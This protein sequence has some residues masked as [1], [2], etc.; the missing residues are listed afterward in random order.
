ME[1][2][3]RDP[4]GRA[5]RRGAR[6]D[7]RAAARADGARAGDA[8]AVRALLPRHGDRATSGRRDVGDPR[9]DQPRRVPA[10]ARASAPGSR[11]RCSR[12]EEEARYGYLAAVNSTTLSDGVALD[13]G[14]GSMQLTRGRAT[15]GR[16]DARSWPLGAVRMTERF[17]R[18]G[19]GQAQAAQGAARA[20][21]RRARGARRGSARRGGRLAGIGGTVR[22]LA[23]AAELAERAAVLRRPGLRARRD[24]LDDLVERLAEL[25]PRRARQRARASSPSAAT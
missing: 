15:G 21:A 9:R 11:S 1:A 23:A 10:R 20:R 13:L 17:L 18:Q 12:R 25:P 7:G 8:R 22:N 2:H 6:G 16:V 14:G 24:A 5:H 19:A 3:G 4:R